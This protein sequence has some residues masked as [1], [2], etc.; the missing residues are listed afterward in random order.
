[1]SQQSTADVDHL[2]LVTEDDEPVGQA[3]KMMVHH[4]GLLHRAFSVF[5]FNQSDQVLLQK[6]AAVERFDLFR[7]R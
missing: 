3:E 5:L 2:V 6:R 1:M 4:E 7:R